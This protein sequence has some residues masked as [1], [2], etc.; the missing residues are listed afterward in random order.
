MARYTGPRLRVIR[1]LGSVLPGLMRTDP[2]LRRP[3][4]PGQH[5]PTRRAKLS[6]YALRLREKQKLRFHYGLSEKQLRRYVAKAF[7]AKG[8]PGLTL[9]SSLESRLDSVLFRM[10]YAPTIPAARQMARHGHIAVNGKRV[11]VPSYAVSQGDVV[12]PHANTKMKEQIAA[13][14]KDPNNL[15]IP[16]YLVEADVADHFRMATLPIREDIPVIVE[17]QKIVEFYSGK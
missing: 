2:E 6:D 15:A 5:G 9:L 13:N 4:A 12:G 11:D 17:E 7:R 10:G 1:R 8:N 3:Y 14:R 16:S